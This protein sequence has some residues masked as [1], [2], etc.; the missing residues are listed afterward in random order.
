MPSSTRL[1]LTIALPI[2]GLILLAALARTGAADPSYGNRDSESGKRTSEYGDRTS[3]ATDPSDT[4]DPADE[5]G[6]AKD[7]EGA[8]LR[9][10]VVLVLSPD[11]RHLYA[12]NRASG[13]ISVI[14][15]ESK[16]VA[17]E[18]D[19]GRQLSDMVA[20]PER[21]LL[22]VTDEAAHELI[23]IAADGANLTVRQRLPVSGYP[24][25]LAISL[26]RQQC[27]V[28]S[29]WSRRLTFV[30]LPERDDEPARISSV[31]DMPFAPRKVLPLDDGKRLVV[32]DAFGGKLAIVD[33][34]EAKVLIV[35]EI[36]GHN[37]RGLAQSPDANRLLV[38]HQMLNELAHTVHNDV[39]WGL[40][41]TNDLRWL[42]LST[43]L[44]EKTEILRGGH[45]HPLGGPGSATGDPAGVA[46]AANGKVVVTL[47]GVG[48][49]AMGCE[50]D[51]GLFRVKVGKRPTGVTIS[52]DGATAYV[53][54]M[55]SDSV[56]VVD[57]E[58]REAVAE[59]S[60]GPQPRLSAVEQGELLFYNARLSHDGWMSCQS[61]HT[62]G[63]T[64]GMLNDNF[65]DG[66]FGAPKRVL[67][68]G[69]VADTAPYA[70]NGETEGLADQIRRSIEHTMQGDEPATTRQV[71]ALA[72]FLR[73]LPTPPPIDEARD[74]RDDDAVARGRELF[75]ALSCSRCHE[76][77]LYTTPKTYDVGLEDKLENRRF[78]PPSLRGVGQRGPY[79]HD[80]RASTLR[81]VFEIH[82]HQLR[83]DLSGEEI[84]DLV[85]FLRSL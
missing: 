26:N 17:A 33:I 50:S 3:G 40:L 44:D 71:E 42:K 6:D 65:S 81:D 25:G 74:E 69:G 51:F 85:A 12:A 23:F 5:S 63:H 41:M 56:S 10:P 82:G 57:L 8:R 58:E 16:S 68:L 62:D 79:F 67:S 80:N 36:P 18:P 73:S 53:A 83:R 64:N 48:E 15:L 78:N 66:S 32:A 22:L 77:P 4:S 54:N 70:W 60:L 28:T 29:L 43:V 84:D 38:A 20:L 2:G 7:A 11:E 45:M 46:I 55:F 13:S 52:R 49:V 59:I 9:R 14:D 34:E 47:G 24:V 39:H 19:V 61:C 31:L 37:I 1:L 75:D 21:G 27:F 76:P 30:D 35:R 72:A